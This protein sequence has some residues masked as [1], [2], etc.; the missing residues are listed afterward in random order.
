MPSDLST[1]Q[2]SSQPFLRQSRHPSSSPDS[3]KEQSGHLPAMEF[4]EDTGANPKDWKCPE[5]NIAGQLAKWSGFFAMAVQIDNPDSNEVSEAVH[6]ALAVTLASIVKPYQAVW[7]QWKGP[8]YGCV[9]PDIN[10]V[11]GRDAALAL[12]QHLAAKRKETV[13]VG[14]AQYP[15]ADFSRNQ[16]LTN[17]C[18]ALDHAAFFGPGGIAIFDSVTL[19]I[20][21][22][23]YYQNGRIKAAVAEYEQALML[24]PNNINVYNSLGVCW[25]EQR[26]FNAARECFQTAISI[27]PKEAMAAYNLGMVHLLSK[28]NQQALDLFKKAYGL[29]SKTF[30]I[31]YH[32]GKVLVEQGHLEKAKPFLEKAIALHPGSSSAFCLLGQCLTAEQKISEAIKA[33]K[34]AVKLSPNDAA[35]LAALG[36]LYDQKGENKD[37][38]LT[39]SRQSV[40][41]SPENGQFRFQLAQLYHKYGDHEAALSEYDRALALGYDCHQQIDELTTNPI[42]KNDLAAK[43]A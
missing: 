40:V 16:T 24:D 39:F 9:L 26:Q 14:L 29:N 36:C 18:K 34:K 38:C 35:A 3:L 25:A 2:H 28:E 15:L 7:F 43:Y 10:A 21:G 33:Y 8:L 17:A 23:R 32:I 27:S 13:T 11:Q 41:L 31:P 4:C 30:Q 22:D 5:A 12:Q 42:P 19:N 6:Q 1:S 37:I 20:S